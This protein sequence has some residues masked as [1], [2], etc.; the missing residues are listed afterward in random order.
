MYIIHIVVDDKF[1]DSA[2]RDFE[3]VAPGQNIFIMPG[4]KRKLAYVKSSA[5]EFK[6]HR[7][8]REMVCSDQCRGLVFHSLAGG[9]YR[10]LLEVP[11]DVTV[12]WLGW[13]YD[14]YNLLLS[15]H[16]PDGFLLPKT[17]ALY[18]SNYLTRIKK[19]I[20]DVLKVL[21]R[22]DDR[23]CRNRLGRVDYF[24]PVI[25]DEHRLALELNKD[26]RPSYMEWNYSTAED[27]RLDNGEEIFLGENI[28]VGNSAT[29]ENNHIEAF[30]IIAAM[31]DLAGRKIV[32]PL[33]YGDARCRKEVIGYGA[34]I[35]GDA[36]MPLVDFVPKDKYIRVLS[37][38]GYVVM[39]H[40]R[41]QA[42][43]NIC[44]SALLGSKIFMN[45]KSPL[46]PWLRGIDMTIDE[47]DNLNFRPLQNADTERNKSAIHRFWGR[48]A[49]LLKTRDLVAAAF[50]LNRRYSRSA[51]PD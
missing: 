11:L 37:S 21:L 3:E 22:R 1:I 40:I 7:K 16:F 30:N 47:L 13:G 18:E 39:N 35:F 15:G 32:V 43:G 28:Q 31:P 2:V 26:F 25:S 50:D 36:F 23:T 6:T 33:S 5:V 44:I 49:K 46:L 10:Q 29:W 27:M 19:G 34:K 8:I 20:K 51:K 17:K 38:C 42:L 12:I 48:E 24:I 14:Y 41:Q 4:R 45:S 9:A